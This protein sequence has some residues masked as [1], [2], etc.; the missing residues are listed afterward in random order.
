MEEGNVHEHCFV[1]QAADIIF[2]N[3]EEALEYLNAVSS[4]SYD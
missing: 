1:Y 4:R 2:N 3:T